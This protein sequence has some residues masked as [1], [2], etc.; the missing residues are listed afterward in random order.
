M[1][2]K[3]KKLKIGNLIS[4]CDE[5]NRDGLNYPFYGI[6]I[7]KDFMPT[8]ASTSGLDN[9][10]YKIV[11]KNRFVFSGMQTGRDKCIRIALYQKDNPV[12]VSPAYTTFEISSNDVLP[13]YFFMIFKSK[14]MD[15]YG[16]FLSDSSVRA[17]LDWNRFCDI[18]LNVPSI[19]VQKKYVAVYESLESNLLSYENG[20]DDLRLVYEGFFDKLKKEKEKAI[21]GDFI[22]EISLKNDSCL[23]KGVLGVNSSGEFGPTKAN[24]FGID[25]TKYKV[26]RKG[27]FAYNPSRINLGSI[28]MLDKDECIV[29][30]MYVVFEIN[31]EK[32]LNPI[33]LNI[34]LQRKEFLRS[35]MFYS[36]GSV[37]DTFDFNLMC[38][39]EI[40]LPSIEIQNSIANIF[41]T[42]KK[43]K[44]ILSKL[45][46]TIDSICPILV[47]GS[48]LEVD[49]GK[50]DAN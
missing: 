23:V 32:K 27:Q 9:T 40:P 41:L 48:L 17:N 42:I 34:W 21:L 1:T 16:A 26:V 25:T 28:A 31:D 8:V 22:T 35:T 29:S 37:R 12:L 11:R 38:K 15:R 24:M 44:S 45:K 5:V 2:L 14:E 49:G 39:V 10:K 3:T 47:R 4:I 43:R 33:Y 30:P 7:D 6:N 50:P 13:A 46:S 36:I 18:E 20:L 19:E